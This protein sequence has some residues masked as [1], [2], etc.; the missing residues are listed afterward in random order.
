MKKEGLDKYI[1]HCKY[2][3]GED[4]FDGLGSEDAKPNSSLLRFYEMKWVEQCLNYGCI[5][6]EYDGEYNVVGAHFMEVDE[7]PISLKALLFNRYCKTA[8]TMLDAVEPFMKFYIEYYTEGNLRERL[9]QCRYYKGEKECP[10]ILFNMANRAGLF[11][12]AEKYYTEGIFDKNQKETLDFYFNCGLPDVSDKM[13]LLLAAGMFSYFCRYDDIEPQKNAKFFQETVL[14]EYFGVCDLYRLWFKTSYNYKT[15]Q[16]YL[17]KC[18]YYNGEYE[19]PERIK[20]IGKE[21][22]WGYE[23]IWVE[24]HFSNNSKDV[25]SNEKFFKDKIRYYKKQGLGHFNDK[26]GVPI[27]FKAMLLNRYEYWSQGTVEGFKEW[28][29]EQYLK[30]PVEWC[31]EHCLFYRGEEDCPEILKEYSCYGAW[32]AESYWVREL[33]ERGCIPDVYAHSYKNDGLSYFC[34]NDGVHKTMKEFLYGYSLH[35]AEG[36]MTPEDFKEWYNDIY[37][38]LGKAHKYGKLETKKK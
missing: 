37:I 31:L 21:L 27:S 14:P 33:T 36:M 4:E 34:M 32:V 23:R 9:L 24:R 17:D 2:Y 6:T 38:P 19:A 12:Q 18:R 1:K 20:E 15:F 22:M 10:K 3:K 29:K 30:M 5:P 8:W 11:W 13:P 35:K 28:Y 16:D 25:K 7:R 26:D